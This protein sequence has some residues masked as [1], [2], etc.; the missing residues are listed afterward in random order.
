MI[1]HACIYISFF[2]DKESQTQMKFSNK[3]GSVFSSIKFNR[4][5]L[6]GLSRLYDKTI[7][8]SEAPIGSFPDKS[9]KIYFKGFSNGSNIYCSFLNIKF[10]RNIFIRKSIT[11][12]IK[13]S[14]KKLEKE[15]YEVDIYCVEAHSPFVA[16]CSKIKSKIIKNK[17]F[18]SLDL[19][20]K[21]NFLKKS[22]LYRVLKHFDNKNILKN[23]SY[24]NKFIFLTKHMNDFYKRETFFVFNGITNS[25]FPY[26]ESRS[27]ERYLLY[28]G[29]ISDEYCDFKFLKD[30]SKMCE[31]E[32]IY[33]YVAGAGDIKNFHKYFL[34][35][36][37]VKYLGLLTPD[38]LLPYINNCVGLINTRPNNEIF[39]YS[40]PSKIIEYLASGKPV[41]S[42]YL[43]C[44]SDD[45][46]SYLNIPTFD[47]PDAFFEKIFYINHINQKEREENYIKQSRFARKFSIEKVCSEIYNYVRQKR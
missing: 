20:N 9:K 21:M 38:E 45:I 10:L 14:L 29:T 1:K 17:V 46:L 28:T 33:I 36:S 43:S 35:C 32:H 22:L 7:T 5:I 4:N 42:R 44:F 3:N 16:A 23:I 37:N 47:S 11:K 34:D 39:K 31:K 12:N 18:V 41:V 40:F 15:E 6:S 13:K 25:F 24:F 2:V 26:S 30:I 19:P 8:I 27:E